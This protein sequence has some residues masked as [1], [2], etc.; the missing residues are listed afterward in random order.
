[1]HKIIVDKQCGCFKRAGMPAEKTFDTKDD[2]LMQG[3]EWV[4]EMNNKF[5]KKHGFT[6]IEEGE[7]FR[8]L[9]AMK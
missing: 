9:M 6:L 4:H 8:I 5:C 7:N 1:M 2:A 3:G